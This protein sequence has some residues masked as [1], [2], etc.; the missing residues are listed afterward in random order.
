MSQSKQGELTLRSCEE[1]PSLPGWKEDH[2]T[3]R[4]QN[5]V[6]RLKVMVE[7][8]PVRYPQPVESKLKLILM[9]RAYDVHL[10]FDD[11]EDDPSL[12]I[13]L[14]ELPEHEKNILDMEEML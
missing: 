1:L 4:L 13:R 10:R 8:D 6:N 3:P 12:T 7:L 5:V 14:E 9:G 2:G 11:S